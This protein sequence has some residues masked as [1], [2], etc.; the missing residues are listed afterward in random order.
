MAI[1]TIAPGEIEAPHPPPPKETA[2]RGVDFLL[3]SFVVL[4]KLVACCYFVCMY[5]L[6]S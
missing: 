3:G 2:V 1:N 6:P 4:V 5:L